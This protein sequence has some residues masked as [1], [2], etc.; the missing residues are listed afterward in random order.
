MNVTMRQ[1]PSM[2]Q[3]DLNFHECHNVTKTFL[4]VTLWHILSCTSQ[5]DIN[6][7][8]CCNVTLAFINVIMWYQLWWKMVNIGQ[9]WCT[10]QCD[11]NFDECHNVSSNFIDVI[12]QTSTLMNVELWHSSMPT[13]VDY[14]Q[15]WSTKF[16]HGHLGSTMVIHCLPW[17]TTI[18]HDHPH[19]TRAIHV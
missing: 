19:S 4:Y 3:Y 13:T 8:K 18:N 16:N 6:F 9:L 5:C 2:S 11:I 10:L 12:M 1:N 14:G 7:H 15:P 17:L